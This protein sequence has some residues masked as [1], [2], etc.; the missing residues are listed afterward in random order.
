MDQS[1]RMNH[2]TGPPKRTECGAE[3]NTNNGQTQEYAQEMR[4]IHLKIL[5]ILSVERVFLPQHWRHF[6]R[7]DLSKYWGARHDVQCATIQKSVCWDHRKTKENAA[8]FLP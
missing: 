1:L 3:K 4:S 6:F 7:K 2:Y 5:Q 8:Y